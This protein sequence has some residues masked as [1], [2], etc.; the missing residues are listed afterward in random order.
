MSGFYRTGAQRQH[1]VR[2]LQAQ[3]AAASILCL[4][5]ISARVRREADPFRC[6]DPCPVNPAGHRTIASCG[7][8]VCWHC[9]KIFWS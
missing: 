3:R 5:D 1:T 7:E 8:V 9:A 2:V 4:E 6:D